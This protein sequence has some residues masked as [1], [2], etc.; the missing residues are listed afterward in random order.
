[1]RD[2]KKMPETAGVSPVPGVHP[3]AH[4]SVVRV[5]NGGVSVGQVARDEGPVHGTRGTFR[6]PVKKAGRT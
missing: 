2:F 6:N 1:M 3:V 4:M 5:G